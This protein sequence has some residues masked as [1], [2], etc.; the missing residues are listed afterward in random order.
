MS[1]INIV[2]GTDRPGS[3]AL[4]I[5]EYLK[6]KYEAEGAEVEVISLKD[7]PISS[8][9]GGVYGKVIPEIKA[10]NERFLSGDGV[11]FVVAEYNCGFPG[12]IKLIIDYFPHTKSMDNLPVAFICEY[13]GPFGALRPIEQLQLIC[14]Y[15][16]A[17]NFPERVFISDVNKQFDSETGLKNDFIQNLLDQQTKNFVTFVEQMK[18]NVKEMSTLTSG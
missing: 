2:S 10:F 1:K 9:A 11:V 13:A 5:S 4:K 15:R 17:F 16:N 18:Q 6:P 8:V 3:N 14:N 12:I 7:F